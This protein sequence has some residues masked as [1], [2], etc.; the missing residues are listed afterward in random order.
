LCEWAGVTSVTRGAHLL[1]DG[2]TM[3]WHWDDI[4][5]IINTTLLTTK[6]ACQA[7]KL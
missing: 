2:H 7:P 6:L 1:A 3:C 5:A 4:I